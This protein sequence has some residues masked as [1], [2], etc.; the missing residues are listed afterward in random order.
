MRRLCAALQHK[1]HAANGI[2]AA[3]VEVAAA[4]DSRI[5]S[6]V[7]IIVEVEFAATV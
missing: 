5:A 4:R 3:K 6:N 2:L 1:P 7:N